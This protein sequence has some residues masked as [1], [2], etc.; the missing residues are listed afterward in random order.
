MKVRDLAWS[1]DAHHRVRRLRFE[2]RSRLPLAALGEV[3]R[4]IAESMSRSVVPGVRVAFFPPLAPQAQTWQALRAG[5]ILFP[6]QGERM[7][8]VLAVAPADA[9][10]IAAAAL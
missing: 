5:K 10:R 2:C 3:A 1:R 4:S 7:D 8:A 6:L 9:R